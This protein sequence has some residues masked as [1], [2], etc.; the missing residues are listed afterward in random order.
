MSM[1]YRLIANVVQGRSDNL[2]FFIIDQLYVC[3]EYSGL[4]AP[5]TIKGQLKENET[6]EVNEMP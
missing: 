6:M 1:P 4:N 5:L 2:S 3:V